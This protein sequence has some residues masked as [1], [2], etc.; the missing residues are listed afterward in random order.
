M[1]KY[2]ENN[3]TK[4]LLNIIQMPLKSE[5]ISVSSEK[6]MPIIEIPDPE[7][8]YKKYI[9]EYNDEVSIYRKTIKE[10][11]EAN[12]KISCFWVID[13]SKTKEDYIK[14]IEK[15]QNNNSN[16]LKAV[17]KEETIAESLKKQLENINNKIE[18]ETKKE[19]KEL[20]QKRELIDQEILK[21]KEALFNIKTKIELNNSKIKDNT[22]QLKYI[23]KDLQTNIDFISSA[24][25]DNC[26]CPMCNQK[27]K[28]VKQ[29][30]IYN[31]ILI[32][33]ENQEK[34]IQELNE[35][36][37]KNQEENEEMAIDIVKIKEE[38][39]NNINFKE[40]NVFS[41]KKKS[42][43]ILE[44]ESKRNQINESL[45]NQIQKIEETKKKSGTQF[46]DIELKLEKLYLSI[47]NLDMLN[48][49]MEII[50]QNNK[51]I[52]EK[53]ITIQEIEKKLTMLKLYINIKWKIIS[54]RV[55]YVFGDDF[56]IN[57]LK[58]INYEPIRIFE[59][60]YKN[61][62]YEN[63]KNTEKQYVD[64]IINKKIDFLIKNS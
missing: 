15:I 55:S 43:N 38:L 13:P 58:F 4:L 27:I 2:D 6:L 40:N 49:Q 14:E 32:K 39:Q 56:K 45:I 57:L 60:I 30:S 36:I 31:K 61:V 50:N 47:K 37:K 64:S 7:A 20:K 54:N 19:D 24:E 51:I 42:L 63:L 3:I 53:K 33:K 46:H 8:E 21:Q 16:L 5:I 1:M 26:K 12:E 35:K 11:E 17:R 22:E 34:I 52:K 23:L 29:N 18:F 25:E 44:L 10:N 48:D 28:S 9:K 62:P 59:I 41:Y